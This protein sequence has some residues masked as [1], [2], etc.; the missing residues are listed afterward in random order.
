MIGQKER[1]WSRKR[2]GEKWERD[3]AEEEKEEEKYSRCTWPGETVSS[4]GSH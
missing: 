4:K 1:R 3:E 2:E